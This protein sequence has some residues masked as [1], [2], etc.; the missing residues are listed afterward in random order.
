MRIAIIGAGR[1]GTALGGRWRD[2]GHEVVYG[3]RDPADSRHA[4]L[5]PVASSADAARGADVVLLALPWPATEAVASGL[6]V[7]EAVVIDATNPLAAGEPA[8]AADGT[9]SGA[10]LVAGWTGSAR[11]VKAF[12]TTGA[13]N[14]ADPAYGAVRPWMPVAGDD[15][16]AKAVV[17]DLAGAI[18]FD[19]ADA[20]PLDAARD[21]EHLAAIWIRMAYR[22][23]Q[24]PGIAFALLRR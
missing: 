5:G 22:L 12:N 1:V 7:G 6:A 4:A 10:R 24:G 3:V 18:G 20:G 13:A 21:L 17:M 9:L 15:E 23:G 19:A 16:Q 11:V 14:M 8:L 2:A